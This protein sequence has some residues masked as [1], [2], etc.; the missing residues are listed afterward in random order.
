MSIAVSF[1]LPVRDMEPAVSGLVRSAAD[2]GARLTADGTLRV[3]RPASAPATND[4]TSPAEALEILAID[5]SSGDNTLA[6]LSILH[7][8]IP[9][10]RTVQELAPGEAI[11]RAARLAR[12]GVWVVVDR[13]FDPELAT[14]A[15]EQV[16]SGQPA[17]IVPAHVLAVSAPLGRRVL[18]DMRGGLVRA[19]EL[20]RTALRQAGE[21]PAFAAAPA[22]GLVERA[23]RVWRARAAGLGLAAWDQPRWGRPTAPGAGH[24]RRSR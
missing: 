6:V 11:G 1:V 16:L 21:Q 7:G 8:Q 20:V 9:A 2:V 15:A 4:G 17:A 24:R 3:V 10:L 12:G 19:Q 22:E 13:P 14:W 18:A 5:Q 23:H